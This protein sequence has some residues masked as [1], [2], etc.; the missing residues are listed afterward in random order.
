MYHSRLSFP[1]CYVVTCAEP[2]IVCVAFVTTCAIFVTTCAIFVTTCVTFIITCITFVI[3]CV[4]FD[5]ICVFVIMCVI[6][7]RRRCP[8]YATSIVLF[9][10][11]K[12]IVFVITCINS[13]TT[14]V[15]HVTTSVVTI[16][17]SI[18]SPQQ[19]DTDPPFPP[20]K[21]PEKHYQV[22]SGIRPILQKTRIEVRMQVC[23][24][25]LTTHYVVCVYYIFLYKNNPSVWAAIFSTLSLHMN[26]YCGS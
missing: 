7:C 16:T 11:S 4:V 26:H 25:R 18:F 6:S 12:C 10:V 23:F 14:C 22:P 13:V 15:V 1:C 9:L 8:F 19:E 21:A 24:M 17:I 2:V 20:P 5:V 3:T